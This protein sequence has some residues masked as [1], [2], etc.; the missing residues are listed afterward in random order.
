MT[1]GVTP[2]SGQEKSTT[3]K[4]G[5]RLRANSACRRLSE[6]WFRS[7]SSSFSHGS[8]LSTTEQA[9]ILLT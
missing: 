4:E 1:C 5:K 2:C 7:H 9:Q 6:R 8:R 3:R